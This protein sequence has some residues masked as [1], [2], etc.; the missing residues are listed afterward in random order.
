MTR[1]RLL[2]ALLLAVVSAQFA[3]A[4]PSGRSKAATANERAL[5]ADPFL[6]QTDARLDTLYDIASRLVS[7][8]DR[9]SL[10]D[11]Q[12]VWVQQRELCGIDKNCMHAAYAKRA[13]VFET[14]LQRAEAHGPL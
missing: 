5:C 11:S 13:S 2:S 9:S 8:E 3:F 6:L 4:L 12:R 14:I 1:S 10:L 7:A